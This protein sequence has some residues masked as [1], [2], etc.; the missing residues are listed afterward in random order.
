MRAYTG[1]EQRNEPLKHFAADIERLHG[2]LDRAE[3][4]RAALEEEVPVAPLFL[5]LSTLRPCGTMSQGRTD[6]P[7]AC[8]VIR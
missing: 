3:L 8:R 5:S 7:G 1:G 4:Q 2:Q 6:S